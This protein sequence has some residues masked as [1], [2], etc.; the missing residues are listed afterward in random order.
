M[1]II[2]L[3]ASI[4]FLFTSIK[5]QVTDTSDWKLKRYK[6]QDENFFISHSTNDAEHYA[7]RAN[8][9]Y[10]I[11]QYKEAVIDYNKAILLAPKYASAYN[12]RGLCEYNLQDNESAIKDY[13][14]ALELDSN[15]ALAYNNRGLSRYELNNFA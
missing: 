1:K 6:I 3:S 9:H 7:K 5:A 15:Y 14:K 11:K 10:E 13:N 12:N 4:L 8:L 2:V